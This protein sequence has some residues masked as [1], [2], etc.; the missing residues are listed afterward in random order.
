MKAITCLLYRNYSRMFISWMFCF[1]EDNKII[2]GKKIQLRNRTEKKH[3]F[4]THFRL[5]RV[6]DWATTYWF[7]LHN[8]YLGRSPCYLLRQQ[9]FRKTSKFSFYFYIVKKYV[10]Y[11]HASC[12]IMHYRFEWHITIR[13][14]HHDSI[15][16]LIS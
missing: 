7:T 13:L 1:V 2:S 4:S 14:L 3:R 8:I 5:S 10:R 11:N 12:V 9:I 16:F 6:V 15:T